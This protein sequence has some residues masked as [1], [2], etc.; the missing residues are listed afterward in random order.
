M[1]NL[2]AITNVVLL[3]YCLAL[4]YNIKSILPW[5]W[6]NIV[7]NLA[8]ISNTILPQFYKSVYCSNIGN[9]TVPILN[10]ILGQYC[11]NK[12]CYVGNNILLIDN[13]NT[14]QRNCYWFEAALESLNTMFAFQ[15]TLVYYFK[16]HKLIQ[17]FV[18]K[19]K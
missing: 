2:E 7:A 16:R 12:F 14:E 8:V 3:Q 11:P 6:R 10:T 19:S 18:I 4:K 13:R 5:Y 9:D 17:H 15:P 1:T